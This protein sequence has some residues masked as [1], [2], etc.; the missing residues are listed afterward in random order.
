MKAQ[1]FELQIFGQLAHNGVNI[2]LGFW[3]RVPGGTP[4]F[5]L[6]AECTLYTGKGVDA[7]LPLSANAAGTGVRCTGSAR[8]R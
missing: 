5:G 6:Q 4:G 8:I 2:I 7:P 3:V 1:Y